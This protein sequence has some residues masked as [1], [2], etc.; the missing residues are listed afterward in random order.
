MKRSLYK[1][2]LGFLRKTSLRSEARR[3]QKPLCGDSPR[4]RRGLGLAGGAGSTPRPT[5]DSGVWD[6]EP[7]SRESLHAPGKLRGDERPRAAASVASCFLPFP[8]GRCDS[9]FGQRHTLLHTV[10]PGPAGPSRHSREPRP[11]RLRRDRGP[12]TARGGVAAG[13]E[14]SSRLRAQR[15]RSGTRLMSP[16][17]SRDPR[18]GGSLLTG[19][20]GGRTL[21]S[22]LRGRLDGVGSDSRR[23]QT[24]ARPRGRGH[25]M[26]KGPRRF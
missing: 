26:L 7:G 20:R 12:A 16:R 11:R 14:G 8:R 4:P 22:G 19:P 2:G 25:V 6:G 1:D 15:L 5:A 3:T 13:G 10:A 24:S 18:R 17:G 23:P 9:A 21:S